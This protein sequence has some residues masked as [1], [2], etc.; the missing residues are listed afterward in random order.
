MKPFQL[1]GSVGLVCILFVP[2][3]GVN[4]SKGQ[5]PDLGTKTNQAHDGWKEFRLLRP[6]SLSNLLRFVHDGKTLVT[7]GTNSRF[8][9]FMPLFHVETPK[10]DKTQRKD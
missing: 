6:D 5:V 8:I 4:P 10:S 3:L 7:A 2:G 1:I 9:G